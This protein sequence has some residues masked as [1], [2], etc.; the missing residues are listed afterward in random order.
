[1]LPV[2]AP[3]IPRRDLYATAGA[4]AKGLAAAA[5]TGG[6]VSA[7]LRVA[8]AVVLPL[9]LLWAGRPAAAA[10]ENALSGLTRAETL[11][12][13]EI[14]DG[15]T[16][17]LADGRQVRLV[18][19]QAPK[20]PLGRP[21]FKA[22]PLADEAKAELAELTLGREVTLH[23]GGSRIDRHGRALAHLSGE[24]GLWIQG[25]L[26]SRGLARVYSFADNRALVPEMLAREAAAR[27]T[28]LGLWADPFYSVLSADDAARHIGRFELVQGRALKVAVV[29]GRAY[30]NFG[31][32]WKTDFTASLSPKV[33]RRFLAEGLDPASYE[34]RMLRIRGWVK[35]Y[36]GAMI[37]VTHPEQIEVIAE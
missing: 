11:A 21:G 20:L 1:M 8:F 29:R 26:L 7:V 2:A 33:R 5:P 9:V 32:D 30:I 31:P 16:L 37:E 4:A 18:G 25:E 6:L 36:N 34:G 15:D 28:R 35:S 27:N 17:I 24:A 14:V 12:V 3:N 19:I 10:P 23:Y 22:W 13:S